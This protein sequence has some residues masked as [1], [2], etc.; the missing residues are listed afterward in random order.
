VFRH[1]RIASDSDFYGR[2]FGSFLKEDEVMLEKHGTEL[3]VGCGPVSEGFTVEE[4][5]RAFMELVG[6]PEEPAEDELVKNLI[7][8]AFAVA[9]EEGR[10]GLTVPE[11]VKTLIGRELSEE[12]HDY[13][14]LHTEA[15]AGHA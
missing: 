7:L 9:K 8:R 6:S 11:V 12:E 5:V 3:I 2:E 13:I 1:E 14:F 4:I 15:P 10:K